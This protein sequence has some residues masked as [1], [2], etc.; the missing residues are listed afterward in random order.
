MIRKIKI[1][2]SNTEIHIF[3]KNNI[4]YVYLKGSALL[5][6]KPYDTLN[7]RM[8]GDIDILVSQKDLSKAHKILIDQGFQEMKSKFNFTKGVISQRHLKRLVNQKFISAVELHEYLFDNKK[9][10][11]INRNKILK[12]RFKTKKGGWV[13]SKTHLW[14]HA[15]LNWQYND[16]GFIYNKFSLRTYLDVV[17]LEND[18][19]RNNLN[20]N[21]F[22][23]HFYSLCSVLVS[24]YPNRDNFSSFIFKNQ[25]RYFFFRITYKFI[26]KIKF[27]MFKIFNRLLLMIYSQRYRYNILKNPKLLLKR[28]LIYWNES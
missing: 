24:I 5:L 28:I 6:V 10:V 9:S 15:I 21:K 12:N 1:K 25:L 17:F 22:V 2:I 16:N 14:L 18:N 7:D 27:L 13:P 8:I 20:N 19:Y 26:I 23:K 11:N 4:E 3:N